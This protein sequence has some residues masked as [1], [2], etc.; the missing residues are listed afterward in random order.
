MPRRLKSVQDNSA[1]NAA[2][3]DVS[4]IVKGV[5]DDIR[6][7]GDAAV[8]QYSQQF[9]SWSPPAFKLSKEEIDRIM[10]SV[11][12]Q[13]IKDIKEVQSNVRRFAEAQRDSIKDFELEIQPGVFLGQVNNPINSVGW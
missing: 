2:S 5:I 3:I 11:S 13:I 1:K 7:K 4:K 9:D 10:A 6:A 8:R 12:P